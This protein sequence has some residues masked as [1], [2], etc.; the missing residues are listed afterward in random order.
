MIREVISRVIVSCN[1]FYCGDWRRNFQ[2]CWLVTSVGVFH[3][4]FCQGKERAVPVDKINYKSRID[5]LEFVTS[6]RSLCKFHQ[7]LC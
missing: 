3:Q 1:N 2:W 6:N 5:S 4:E 7:L